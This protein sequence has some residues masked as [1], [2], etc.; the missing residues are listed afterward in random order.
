MLQ[1]LEWKRRG[2]AT[3]WEWSAWAVESHR[4]CA[5]DRAAERRGDVAREF[6]ASASAR[7][8]KE[9]TRGARGVS[10]RRNGAVRPGR[11]DLDRTI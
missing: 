8:T 4:C 11:I 7:R 2:K 6:C 9:L 3:L 10:E 1:R 5:R